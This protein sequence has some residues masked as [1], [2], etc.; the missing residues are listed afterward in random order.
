MMRQLH[1]LRL[2][3]A[4]GEPPPPNPAKSPEEPQSFI[5][6]LLVLQGTSPTKISTIARPI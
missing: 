6:H 2:L 5:Y 1:T 3:H 4:Q